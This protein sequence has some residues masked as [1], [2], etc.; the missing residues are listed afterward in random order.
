MPISSDFPN[1]TAGISEVMFNYT[2]VDSV[3]FDGI[4]V[5]K[6][7]SRPPATPFSEPFDLLQ[8]EDLKYIL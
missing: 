2:K 3:I 7:P 4:E 1:N 8:E 6:A 5:F